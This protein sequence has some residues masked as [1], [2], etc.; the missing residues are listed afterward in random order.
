MGRVHEV[1]LRVRH[2]GYPPERQ[3]FK[4]LPPQAEDST[5]PKARSPDQKTHSQLP[6]NR[7]QAQRGRCSQSGRGEAPDLV[8]EAFGKYQGLAC[9]TNQLPCNRRELQ[10]RSGRSLE[11]SFSTQKLPR[12]VISNRTDGNQ[13]QIRPVP[14]ST[15]K[16]YD[17]C[18]SRALHEGNTRPGVAFGHQP[19]R[20]ALP[21]AARCLSAVANRL[22]QILLS[23]LKPR[24]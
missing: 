10:G 15:M 2:S 9:S 13:R 3:C 23:R 18:L 22:S 17:E 5:E 19:S 11:A 8:R 16:L 4:D 14:H 12:K 24:L 6:E 1:M 20:F 21:K 7:S